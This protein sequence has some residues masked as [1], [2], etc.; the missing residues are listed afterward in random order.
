VKPKTERK[1]FVLMNMAN[2]ELILG[3]RVS[4]IDGDESEA[5]ASMPGYT[6]GLVKHDGWIVY[7]P[8]FNVMFWVN[9]NGEKYFENLGEL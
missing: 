5:V 6:I 9:I 3:Y 7:T 8:K 4:L 1:A 2:A